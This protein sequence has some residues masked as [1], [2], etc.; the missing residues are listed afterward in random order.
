M[1]LTCQHPT[2]SYRLTLIIRCNKQKFNHIDVDIGICFIRETGFEKKIFS[3]VLRTVKIYK[4]PV[5]LGK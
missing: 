2:F 4:N 3:L 5:S 1:F